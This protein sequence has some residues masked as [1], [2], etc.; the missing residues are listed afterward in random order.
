MGPDGIPFPPAGPAARV[1]R[2]R[3]RRSHVAVA[4]STKDRTELTRATV[5]PLLGDPGIDLFWFDGSATD[6]G[7]AL[8]HQLCAGSPAACAIHGGVTGGPDRAIFYA[9]QTL[10][11]HGY[12]LI[13]L[14]ENDVLVADG[15]YDALRAAMDRARA[16]GFRVGGGSVRVIQ[17]RVL[18]FNDSYCLLLNSGAGFLALTNKAAGIL[19]QH[20]RTC[21]GAELLRHLRYLTGH[22]LTGAVAFS[23]TQGLSADWL[24]DIMLYLHGYAVAAPP[25]SFA[26]NIDLGPSY[27]PVPVIEHARAH[28]TATRFRIARPAQLRGIERPHFSFQKSPV[29]DLSLIGCHQLQ[30]TVN[31]GGGRAPVRLS[32]PWKRRWLQMLGPFAMQG[33]GSVTVSLFGQRA[34]ILL[35]AREPA[36]LTIA[37][38]PVAL[39]PNTVAEAPLSPETIGD[40]DAALRVVTGEVCFIGLTVP[41]T[42]IPYYAAARPSLDHLPD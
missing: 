23:G 25:V 41:D 6:A 31:A 38:A 12:A 19:L 9:L 8:P 11:D 2:L 40:Q 14:I 34:G 32:G 30:L 24:F 4:Y 15:W 5:A 36:E 26:S 37:G 35:L 16:D 1:S 33:T 17:R 27:P 3:D 29:S 7:R 18:S 22:D 21:D 13:I 10:R 20:Y 28:D 42:A 39:A